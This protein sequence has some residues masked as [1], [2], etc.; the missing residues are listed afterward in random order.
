MLPSKIWVVWISY[1]RWGSLSQ[2]ILKSRK[3]YISDID[4][5]YQTKLSALPWPFLH[6]CFPLKFSPMSTSPCI[7]VLLVPY[8]SYPSLDQMH[9]SLST[10]FPSSW[11][12]PCIFA[13][14]LSNVFC[15]I[16]KAHHS[17]WSFYFFYF[18]T[19]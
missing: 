18:Y 5:G 12:S 2:G 8:N 15:A 6:T 17:L 14:N 19:R 1:G 7:E 16:L 4:V 9:L 11:I 10:S 3:R 13:R